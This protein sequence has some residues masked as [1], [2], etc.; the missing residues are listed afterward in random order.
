MTAAHWNT[1]CIS[2][3]SK[4]TEIFPNK[5]Q[6][7]NQHMMTKVLSGALFVVYLVL[8]IW[9]VLFKLKLNLP[10]LFQDQQRSLNL[11]PFEAPAIVNGRINYGEMIL[12]CVIFIPFGLLLNANFK[13]VSFLPKLAIIFAFSLLMELLQYI[14]AIG[15]TDITDLITNTLGGFIGL[16][17][18]N[19]CNKYVSDVKL[20][21]IIIAI[22]VL[23]LLI[24]LF[25]RFI[26]IILR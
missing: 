3:H 26:F 15:A 12:N 20:D 16:H 17:L 19:F 9:L 7:A 24:F 22:G 11:L 10:L 2:K 23:L 4:I 21:R 25:I 6:S 13:K 14:F 1:Y 8:L 18:Y 5:T